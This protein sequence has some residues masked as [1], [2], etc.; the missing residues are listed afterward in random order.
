MDSTETT[1][2]IVP[3]YPLPHLLIGQ[4]AKNYLYTAG[5]W[6]R[7]LGILGFIGTAI[8]A[9]LCV[10]AGA[11]SPIMGAFSSS[12]TGLP[13]SAGAGA[14]SMVPLLLIMILYFFVSYFLYQFGTNIKNGVAVNDMQ[15]VT[16]AFRNLKSHFKL[17]GI[18]LII[19]IVS[20]IVAFIIGGLIFGSTFMHH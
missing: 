11:V 5:K 18:I 19:I 1:E 10:F 16:K 4:E 13:V 7:F 17:I 6:A 14:L 20:Y 15:L 3:D 12:S 2:P 9:L 8:I